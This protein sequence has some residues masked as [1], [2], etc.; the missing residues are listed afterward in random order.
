MA[1]S[2]LRSSELCEHETLRDGSD[3]QVQILSDTIVTGIQ[4]VAATN[5]Q[6]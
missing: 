1:H 5:R 4:D 6:S 2:G 3:D